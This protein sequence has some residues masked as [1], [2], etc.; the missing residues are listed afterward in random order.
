MTWVTPAYLQILQQHKQ[1]YYDAPDQ[2][3]KVVIIKQIRSAIRKT[4]QEE[5]N[6]GHL[7][8]LSKVI[9]NS[10]LDGGFC[11]NITCHA[12]NKNLA[13]EQQRKAKQSC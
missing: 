7:D 13:Q 12:E 1:Q 3:A 4:N 10:N 9:K 6:Q 8:G 5:G 11:A 2:E